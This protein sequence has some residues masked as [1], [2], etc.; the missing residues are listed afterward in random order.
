M[1]IDTHSHV[2]KDYYF[3]ESS[4][5][6]Y[7][8]FCISNNID[9]GF[10]MPM[11][12]P[13]IKNCQGEEY[14][15]IWE[16]D[17]KNKISLYKIF[18]NQERRYKNRIVC[19]PYTEVNE[20]YYNLIHHVNTKTKIF[21]VPLVHGSLDTPE[22]IEDLITKTNPVAIKFHGFSGGFF[23]DDVNLELAE[24]LRFYDIP[25]IIHT[26]V[27]RYNDGYGFETKYWRNKCNPKSWADFLI[28]NNLRGVL[29]HGAC[30]DEGT[31]NLV[32]KSDKIMIGI[33]PDLDIS[34]D[35][36]KVLVD[37]EKFMSIGYLKILKQMVNPEKLLFDLDYNWNTNATGEI[38]NLSV[39]RVFN[40]WT[41]EDCDK[42]LSG[43]A[44]RFYKTIGK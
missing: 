12:W 41:Y 36:Y 35:P 1:I 7:D 23:A 30:L 31:I 42:I 44:K 11:P 8:K 33:G 16:H 25:I 2:G 24:V 4:L 32:N 38:D 5:N 20:Y 27:Y 9:A 19:N 15:F 29:N 37:K 43:N 17:N 6:S 39:E 14:T 21:F 40:T 18:L 13:I 34:N 22:L 28:K 3:G 10:L 26:S